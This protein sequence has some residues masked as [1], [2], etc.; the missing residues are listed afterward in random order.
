[1]W[2]PRARTVCSIAKLAIASGHRWLCLT[3]HPSKMC[4]YMRP[5]VKPPSKEWLPVGSVNPS[6]HTCLLI[7]WIWKRICTRMYQGTLTWSTNHTVPVGIVDQLGWLLLCRSI[8]S[9]GEMRHRLRY[10]MAMDTFNW[11]E[12]WN[13]VHVCCMGVA[14]FFCWIEH[15]TALE[16]G[17]DHEHQA[18]KLGYNSFQDGK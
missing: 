7:Y 12:P 10:T 18:Y 9:P 15:S 14:R 4:R 2:S 16:L 5:W 6:Q 13:A 11:Y 17:C 8:P 1:M 3:V